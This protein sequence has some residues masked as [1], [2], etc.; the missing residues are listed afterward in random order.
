MMNLGYYYGETGDIEKQ[1]NLYLEGLDI[2]S[3][4]G[5]KYEI[6]EVLNNVGYLYGQL[7]D[8]V[9]Q[10]KYYQQSLE[11]KNEI[12]DREGYALTLYNI[13]L[14]DYNSGQ[15]STAIESLFEALAIQDS[16]NKKNDVASTLNALGYIYGQQG[17]IKKQ[18]EMYLKSLEN[19]REVDDQ[20]GIALAYNNIA[21]I[22][23]KE[24]KYDSA[25]I[26]FNDCLSICEEFE[27][28]E[29]EGNA[30]N[31]IGNVLESQGK[32]VE[33]QNY[34][35]RS[36]K[37]RE[38][39]ADLIGLINSYLTIGRLSF[40]SG[41]Y[42]YAKSMAIL[43]L[44]KSSQIG[45]VDELKHSTE[46]LYKSQE[47]LGEYKEG[48]Q[49][50]K[51]FIVLRDSL[52]NIETQKTKIEQDLKYE[53]EKKEALASLG[54]A[55]EKEISRVNQKRQ[56]LIIWTVTIG[57]IV[58]AFFSIIIFY[59]LRESTKQ[60]KIIEIKN[61]ENELLLG[62]IHH[63][64]KNN[65][66]VISSL[67]SLQERNTTDPKT[68]TAILEGKERVASM[69]LIHKMLY[70]KNNFSGINMNEY[71]DNLI[72]GLLSSYGKNKEDF[73]LKYDIENI[74]LDVDSAIPLGLIINELVVN[75]FKHAFDLTSKPKLNINLKEID[76]HLV[77]SIQDNG[78]G[79]KKNVQTSNSFGMKLITSLA[80]QLSGTLE[81]IE[82]E[83]LC[84]L[85]TVSD[86]KV[87]S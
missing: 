49:T 48:L 76:K 15:I 60:K 46:L 74:N 67:L 85:V 73:D 26:F 84:F 56:G 69:G 1:K 22:Y 75:S 17:D 21:S 14:L 45:F 29:G 71:I 61:N 42:Q 9:T 31:N 6:A 18:M 68:K 58:I 25:L 65:L 13:A 33:A 28:T 86:Y 32:I 66:Q 81:I 54:F 41:D 34:Y 50:H 72:L 8:K 7:G 59:R 83:G 57:L 82:K 62:E 11:L 70:Q 39:S 10:R 77:L 80:R 4:V 16:V 35:Q 63:R 19:F 51:K 47:A 78:K 12:G 30:L 3:E 53:Y 23:K 44:D 43:A 5:S 87:S 40:K 64:V 27:M 2:I 52:N 79:S 24:K 38:Q 55:K 36:L 20:N 37:I